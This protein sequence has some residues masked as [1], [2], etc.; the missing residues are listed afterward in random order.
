[1]DASG[2]VIMGGPMGVYERKAYPFLSDEMKLIEQALHQGKPT[3]GICLGSQLLAAALGAEV[4]K[5][6][7]KE[8]G[9]YPVSLTKEAATDP[10]FKG[11]APYFTAYHWHG[12]IFPLPSGA[13]PL[14]SSTLTECQAFRYGEKSYG[15]LFHMEVTEGLIREMVGTF[16]SELEEVSIDPGEIVGKIKEYLP[17]LQEVGKTVFGRW[18]DLLARR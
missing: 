15:L 16:A 13:V 2:L 9:W 6:K 5:G 17:P 18:A 10:L 3:L 14:V 7:R 11:V 4:V 1:M 12:D 8:I